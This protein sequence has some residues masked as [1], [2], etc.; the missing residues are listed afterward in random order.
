M[1]KLN[2]LLESEGFEDIIEFAETYVLESIVPGI[3][4][5]PSCSDVYEYE[6]DQNEGWCESCNSNTVKSGL[7]LA[8]LI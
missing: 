8:G 2:D 3:C 7:I 4:I 5:N 6:P 1:S